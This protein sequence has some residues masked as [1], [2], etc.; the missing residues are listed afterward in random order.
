M[1]CALIVS[2][3][4]R[5]LQVFDTSTPGGFAREI[6]VTV[7]ITTA[8]WLIAT[9][10]TAAEPMQKLIEFYRNVRPAGPGWRP[11]ST[12]AKIPERRGEV[13]PN[14]L[15][16]VLGVVLVYAALFSIGELIF[17]GW[18]KAILL[19]VIGGA[20]GTLMF[21]NLN[22]TGWAGIAEREEADIASR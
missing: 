11:V 17:G 12:A 18:S 9:F 22:R 10:V 21:W 5:Q 13:I 16:W 20:A 15:N 19:I 3:G 4:L 2:L 6:L 14:L 7:G 8:V 1:A